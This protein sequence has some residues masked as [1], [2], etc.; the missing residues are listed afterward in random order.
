MRTVIDTNIFL[1][2]LLNA[3]GGA[4]KIIR[5]FRDGEFDLVITP[6]VFDE[7]VRVLHLFDN[8][9][10]ASKSEE[11]LEHVFE[12]AVKVRPAAARGVCTDTDDEK[13]ISAALAGQAVRLVTKNKKHFHKEVSSI[14]IVT[15]R[16]FLREVEGL[17]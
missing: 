15:V 12:K 14:K 10:P 13:F 3:E 5:A 8:A 6:E 16:E 11:L 7:Y 2:G 9:I 17:R 4:A 1:A